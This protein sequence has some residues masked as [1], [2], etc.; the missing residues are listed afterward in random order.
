LEYCVAHEFFLSGSG[1]V[2]IVAFP[3]DR[4]AEEQKRQACNW[5]H[6]ISQRLRN[7]PNQWAVVLVGTKLD[8]AAPWLRAET[9]TMRRD[10]EAEHVAWM[11]DQC[12]ASL[13]HRA[14][15]VRECVLTSSVR[16]V[17]G[18]QRMDTLR[19]A[20]FDAAVWI[21]EE[22]QWKVPVRWKHLGRHLQNLGMAKK[23]QL[24][25]ASFTSLLDEINGRSKSDLWD[26]ELLE[27]ALAYL[28]GIGVVVA[29]QTARTVCLRPGWLAQCMACFIAPFPRTPAAESHGLLEASQAIKLLSARKL[30][31][32]TTDPSSV[33]NLLEKFGI[34]FKLMRAG[35]D[36]PLYLFPSLRPT[37]DSES[38]D[39]QWGL[40]QQ[41]YIGR[42]FR[43]ERG[44]D[45]RAMCVLPG[46][47]CQ[48]QVR[49]LERL[50]LKADGLPWDVRAASISLVMSADPDPACV[51]AVVMHP[52]GSSIDVVVC[53]ATE[54]ALAAMEM[55][56]NMVDA[57]GNSSGL[58]G[59]WTYLCPF[60]IQSR[61]F[62]SQ[63]F[64]GWFS[65]GQLETKDTDETQRPLW[66]SRYHE[67]NSPR[68][69]L[70]GGPYIKRMYGRVRPWDAPEVETSPMLPF[71]V[72]VDKIG[73][74]VVIAPGSPAFLGG[75]VLQ[76]QIVALNRRRWQR[77][78]G[79]MGEWLRRASLSLMADLPPFLTLTVAR[80][81]NTVFSVRGRRRVVVV[82]VPLRLCPGDT[83]YL[84][85]RT[86]HHTTQ[87]NPPPKK[88][89]VAALL[90]K[91]AEMR[92]VFERTVLRERGQHLILVEQA[93]DDDREETEH[94]DDANT[95]VMSPDVMSPEPDEGSL[96]SNNIGIVLERCEEGGPCIV[97]HLVTSALYAAELSNLVRPLDELVSVDGRT[98][99]GVTRLVLQRW[100]TGPPGTVV[101]LGLRRRV[102][103]TGILEPRYEDLTANLYFGELTPVSSVCFSHLGVCSISRPRPGTNAMEDAPARIFLQILDDFVQFLGADHASYQ[104]E[105]A[106]VLYNPSVVSQFQDAYKRMSTRGSTG[107]TLS[108]GL[109]EQQRWVLTRFDEYMAKF[110][111]HNTIVAAWW[112]GRDLAYLPIGES[113][114]EGQPELDEGYFGR[115]FYFS[116]YPRYSDFYITSFADKGRTE[117]V[118][119]SW[120]L[121][122][123]P[124]PVTQQAVPNSEGSLYGK[125]CAHGSPC[126][127]VSASGL[128]RHD[129][130]YAVVRRDA[131]GDF[132]PCPSDEE[133]EGDEI[134]IPFSDPIGQS[135]ARILPSVIVYFRRRRRT[136]LWVDDNQSNNRDIIRAVRQYRE[137]DIVTVES[138]AAAEE[139]LDNHVE[140]ARYPEDYFRIVS[141]RRLFVGERP[142]G[143]MEPPLG[144]LHALETSEVW[145]WRQVPILIYHGQ[146]MAGLDD[147]KRRRG[148]VDTDD[149]Q[150][151]TTFAMMGT[152]S[153][154]RQQFLQTSH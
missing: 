29:D 21:S 76:D 19:N 118:L 9:P 69:I 30:L 33:M 46:T 89:R 99:A 114:F 135:Q 130:H 67:V 126:R 111:T 59:E 105:R 4:P 47:F 149:P 104:F 81:Q 10:K 102:T 38:S 91:G 58:R 75:L 115:G 142:D 7:A 95:G 86:R 103:V 84:V 133:P 23:Q 144:L 5:L 66:C 113:N 49:I 55:L 82:R 101:S 50:A 63:P 27:H 94:R 150:V 68:L 151:A 92:P 56:Q 60:C 136:L 48:L 39:V 70:E 80:C 96:I 3:L 93:D 108:H 137:V 65:L 53:G 123:R 26:L 15:A 35:G 28:H 121:V 138:V 116:Q 71:G 32:S 8:M 100:L 119:M 12:R 34:C 72:A 62:V 109:T 42:R 74:V 117:S 134:V 139:W 77:E 2:Y 141:N 17:D 11:L 43:T 36:S 41:V 132:Q 107:R 25:L 129:S 14:D 1:T 57:V 22:R 125:T 6:L 45:G 122:G 44:L 13:P 147:A 127:T 73:Q 52:Q 98:V 54:P 143:V 83:V 79:P 131:N 120:V 106:T 18:R 140:M 154:L 37:A 145:R 97:T 148:C 40:P 16:C 31:P 20:V 64:A 152:H 128:E 112:G 85:P 153:T 88:H 51:V 61:S 24:P 110:G 78:D 146:I 124:Y 87:D 90:E